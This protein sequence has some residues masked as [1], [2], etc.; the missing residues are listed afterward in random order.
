MVRKH[1]FLD[2]IQI[3]FLDSLSGTLSENIRQAIREYMFRL[4]VEDVSASKSK[5]KEAK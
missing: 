3:D 4:T 2:K 5:R 1:I